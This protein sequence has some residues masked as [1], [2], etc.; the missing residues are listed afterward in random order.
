[1]SGQRPT[2]AVAGSFMMDLVFRSE[3]RPAAGETIIGRDFGMF[4]GGKGLNQALT[5]RRLGASVEMIGRLGEDPFG[6]QF[7]DLM[8]REGVGIS[9]VTRDAAVGTG[10][11]CPVVTDD[12]ANSIVVVPRANLAVT[13]ADVEAAREVIGRAAVLML[14]LEISPAATWRAAEI[15]KAAGRTVILNPAPAP[16]EAPTADQFR[17]V[18]VITPNEVEA[19]ALTGIDPVDGGSATRAALRLRELGIGTVVLTLGARGALL[20]DDR[21]VRIIP[22]HKVDVVDTTGAGDAFNGGLAY[23]LASGLSADAAVE[24]ANIAGALAVTKLGAVPS[25]PSAQDVAAFRAG[26]AR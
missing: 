23:G 9:H 25:M 8:R 22:G 24:L 26:A 16:K 17:L 21:G 3:R 11:A 10:V 2:I 14:Q 5:A 15:A 1:M 18:D 7:V 12:G 20:A 6:E 13:V 19:Q 4:M